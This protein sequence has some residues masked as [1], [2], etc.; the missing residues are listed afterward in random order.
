MPLVQFSLPLMLT[1]ATEEGLCSME[2]IVE[3]MCHNPAQLFHIEKRGFIRP[4]YKADLVLVKNKEWKIQREDVLSKC[5]WSPLEG[6]TMKWAV[7]KTW[8]NGQCVYD[9]DKGVE[10]NVY[11]KP[12]KFNA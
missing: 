12:L 5:R 11:G 2:R 4:G 7:A 1:L 8:V 3:V 9:K 6:E 10:P